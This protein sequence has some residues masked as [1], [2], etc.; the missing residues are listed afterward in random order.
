MTVQT[1]VLPSGLNVTKSTDI[2]PTGTEYWY[3]MPLLTFVPPSHAPYPTYNL[4]YI[5]TDFA[6]LAHPLLV[7]TRQVSHGSSSVTFALTRSIPQQ[8]HGE[9][10]ARERRSPRLPR[11]TEGL[12]VLVHHLFPLP[13]HPP[14]RSRVCEFLLLASS[15]AIIVGIGTWTLTRCVAYV[16]LNWSCSS[17]NR[18]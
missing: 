17:N 12:E 11:R 15:E 14:H 13:L 7:C 4:P 9:Y 10:S 18:T 2:P 5:Q 3:T 6:H 8:A 1:S 16:D